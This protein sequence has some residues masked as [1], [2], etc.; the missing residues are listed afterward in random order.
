[1]FP[2]PVTAGW[3]VPTCQSAP[4]GTNSDSEEADAQTVIYSSGK[5]EIYECGL[6]I[7]HEVRNHSYHKAYYFL[8]TV[9]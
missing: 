4:S 6:A 5:G 7:G 2:T 1:M 8:H 3:T 9:C